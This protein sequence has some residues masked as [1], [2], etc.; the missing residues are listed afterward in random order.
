MVTGVPD[1]A[2]KPVVPRG[3]DSAVGGRSSHEKEWS[4]F[5]ALSALLLTFVLL[6]VFLPLRTA[7]KI[8]ADE[9]YEL[10]KATLALK[11][12]KFYTDVWNDQP[13]LHT[14]IVASVLE[15]VSRSVL[16]T[17]LVT[18]AFTAVL[19][20]AIFIMAFQVGGLLVA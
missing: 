9:D 15:H 1:R 10:S 6:Q 16:A 20:S 12:Y 14:A 13:L 18:S 5:G 8:G 3:G 19:L 4:A 17:R 2:R 7:V 11:G